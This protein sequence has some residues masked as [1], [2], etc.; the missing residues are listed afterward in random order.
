MRPAVFLPANLV[1]ALAWT[2]LVGLGGY[3]AAFGLLILGALVVAGVVGDR[4][5]RRAR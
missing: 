3:F 2:L 1:A 5:R 4:V